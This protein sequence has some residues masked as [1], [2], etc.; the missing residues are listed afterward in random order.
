MWNGQILEKPES[1][2]EARR[3]IAGYG[4]APPKTVG[5][6]VITDAVTGQQWSAVDEATIFFDPI[7]QASVDQLVAAGEVFFCAVRS[8]LPTPSHNMACNGT[9]TPIRCP[10][11]V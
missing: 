6:C 10:R 4:E 2:E 9:T 5:S 8:R 1:E 3:F 11:P 7:P